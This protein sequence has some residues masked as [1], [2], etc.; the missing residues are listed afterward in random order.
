MLLL[1]RR[2]IWTANM[3]KNPEHE[4]AS[5]D[6]LQTLI[7]KAYANLPREPRVDPASNNQDHDRRLGWLHIT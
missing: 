4:I 3:T 2:T 1:C 7:D 6:V 5:H